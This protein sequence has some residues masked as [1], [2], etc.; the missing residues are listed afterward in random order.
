LAG[1]RERSE[2]A[3]AATAATTGDDEWH[4]ARADYETTAPATAIVTR[5]TRA[6]DGD[7]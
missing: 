1:E 2:G 3:T 7:L 6:A 5:H 4:I